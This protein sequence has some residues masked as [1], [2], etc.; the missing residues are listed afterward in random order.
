MLIQKITLLG[1]KDHGKST[2][3]GNLLIATHAVSPERV[4]EAKRISK[5]LH[6]RFEPGFILDAFSEERKGGLTIDTTRAELAHKG[7]GFEFID[8]P[9]HE[10]L[11][12]NMLTGASNAN[13]AV[14]VVSAKRGE[15]ITSQ[16]KRHLFI[17]KLLG[18]NKIV[19]AVNK[20][21]AV[22]YAEKAF[23]ETAS[24][25]NEYLTGIGFSADALSFVPI[26]AYRSENL[27]KKSA[28]MRWYSGK[29][30]IDLVFDSARRGSN[31]KN[32]LRI[33]LQSKIEGGEVTGRVVS[34]TLKKGER[35]AI[36]PG[37]ST[38][39]V[40]G[41]I[42]AGKRQN[43]AKKGDSVALDL[44]NVADA[45]SK[46]ACIYGDGK[47]IVA[48]AFSAKIFVVRRLQSSTHI[49]L[50][51]SKMPAKI[52]SVQAI[53]TDTGKTAKRGLKPL[54]AANATVVLKQKAAFEKFEDFGELGRFTIYCND[55][56]AGIGTVSGPIQST[57]SA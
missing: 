24:A 28:N 23:S 42:V 47:P 15:G 48:D 12:K 46:I 45:S 57:G 26:S 27:V 52:T 20:M 2:L 32:E 21:D 19:I 14:L 36:F 37:A 18:I 38:A 3:L 43:S 1:H 17:A 40:K 31:S 10:E 56:F 11:I 30:L 29:P 33:L 34:G 44:G 7:V 51:G 39:R 6:R 55:K 54:D 13:V 49:V 8:V 35:L 50:N 5:Q 9:G 53:D 25:L 22:G 41:I 4:K 16:T